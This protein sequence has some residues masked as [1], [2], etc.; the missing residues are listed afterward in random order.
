MKLELLFVYP[1]IYFSPLTVCYYQEEMRQHLQ[2]FASKLAS[3]LAT[4]FYFPCNFRQSVVKLSAS[5]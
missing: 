5:K 1:S 3:L 2:H 4:F